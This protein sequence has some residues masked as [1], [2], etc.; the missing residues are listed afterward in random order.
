MKTLPLL[1]LVCL[2]LSFPANSQ[3][4]E[5]TS[6]TTKPLY[7]VS[8]VDNSVAW[9][10]G[11]A[12][13]IIRTTDGGTNWTIISPGYFQDYQHFWSIFALDAQNALAAYSQLGGIGDITEVYKTTNGGS[14]W[15]IVFEQ[16]GG[17][18]M[19]MYMFSP[20]EGFLYTSPLNG[21]WRFFHT[22]D[23]GYTWQLINEYQESIILEQGHW[24]SS[25]FSGTDVWFGSNSTNI[26]HSHDN[27]YTWAHVPV[28]TQN[29]YSVWFNNSNW[30]LLAGDG[31]LE[32]TTD[33]GNTW[34][35]TTGQPNIDSSSSIYGVDTRWWV[36]NQNHIYYSD[37]NVI[38]WN[39]QY[40]AP[41][42]RYM[43]IAG[44]RNG[45]LII[46]VRG[47]GGISAYMYPV[48]VELSSFTAKSDDDGVILNW[49]TATETNNRGFRIE[50]RRVEDIGYS[51]SA[52]WKDIGFVEGKGTTTDVSSYSYTDRNLVAGLFSYRLIQE[53]F[54]GTVTKAGEV[55]VEVTPQIKKYSL[56]QNYPNPFNPTTNIVY[57]LH[58]DGFVSLKVYN[59]AGE[60]VKR[61][62]NGN[63]TAGRYN[64]NFNA[65]G[66]PSGIYFYRLES[67]GFTSVKKMILL[68]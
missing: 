1:I 36:G 39:T 6:P 22:S 54:D 60:E 48:P 19:D 49:K 3:W 14:S 45:N 24:N 34:G 40:S 8:V 12:G 10:C 2:L 18:V 30:G 31:H 33:G 28:T 11:R 27:G 17:W 35:Q 43:E 23:A 66:L 59:A 41:S 67:G 56:A 7:S 15:A 58:Q 44:A 64:L 62:V 5:Q 26:Y 32:R 4:V 21:Y 53:D 38:F 47:N 63:E 51:K 65:S 25:F 37:D 46:G 29:I 55:N 57:S 42:G 50:R 20:N 16:T 9:A 68:R 13:T 61:L 52:E